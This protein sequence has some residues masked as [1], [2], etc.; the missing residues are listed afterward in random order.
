MSLLIYISG[1]F[2]VLVVLVILFSVFSFILVVVEYVC[3]VYMWRNMKM[4]LFNYCKFVY[5]RSYLIYLDYAYF[6]CCYAA[7]LL[8]TTQRMWF[9]QMSSCRN[10]MR[11]ESLYFSI[12]KKY[13]KVKKL[14]SGFLKKFRTCFECMVLSYISVNVSKE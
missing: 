3:P 9:I 6:R 7:C 2:V 8:L 1:P 12:F 10:Q 4:P 14:H 11:M 13:L 5:F